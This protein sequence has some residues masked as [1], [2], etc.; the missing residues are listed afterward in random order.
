MERLRFDAQAV[1]REL[2]PELGAGFQRFCFELLRRRRPD[3]RRYPAAGRDGGIDLI[4]DEDDGRAVFECKQIGEDGPDAARARWRTVARNLR[5]H[6]PRRSQSQYAPWWETTPPIRRYTLCI[7]STLKNQARHDELT[8]E[9]QQVFAELAESHEHL[10]HLA[11]IQVKVLHWPDLQG[12]LEDS[13]SL[14]FKWF[15]QARPLGLVPVDRPRPASLFSSFL[16]SSHLGYYSR[17]RHMAEYGRPKHIRV[18]SEMDML[19][20]LEETLGLIVTGSGGHGKTRLVQELG[21][22]AQQQ[23]WCVLRVAGSWR[24]DSLARLAG[25]VKPSTPVLLL[26]DYIE[27]QQSFGDVVDELVALHDTNDLPIR[28]VANCRS[29]FYPQVAHL[30][31]HA[32]IPLAPQRGIE[33]FR[34]FRHCVVRHILDTGGVGVEAKTL[35][36]CRDVPV[37]AVFLV[38]LAAGGRDE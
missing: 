23:G 21:V 38:Y 17:D 22:L 2:A 28:Y 30:P 24:Q 37:L 16:D 31:Q 29:S 26:L 34:E 14:L 1:D 20:R 5:N 35:Q 13:P 3:L 36:V 4:D 8:R 9:I 33:W 18:E 11:Q 10:R 25:I 19:A 12:E 7:S 27:M 32:E 15:P 6:L